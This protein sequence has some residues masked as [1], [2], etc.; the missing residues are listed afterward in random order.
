MHLDN[1]PK[2][3]FDSRRNVFSVDCKRFQYTQRW[4]GGLEIYPLGGGLKYTMST[5]IFYIYAGAGL[6]Y[7]QYKESNPLGD[8]TKGG[9]GFLGKIGS[10]VKVTG[11]LLG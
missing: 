10:Y 11:G 4:P 7:Y 5:G 3:F 1:T 8:V 6:N 9:L 2:D